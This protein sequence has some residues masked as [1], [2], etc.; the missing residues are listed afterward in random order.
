MYG[1]SDRQS[2]GFPCDEI[3]SPDR[4]SHG[5]QADSAVF[6]FCDDECCT[7]R[8]TTQRHHCRGARHTH[9]RNASI[10]R[11]FDP[12]IAD[13][14]PHACLTG[15]SRDRQEELT[16]WGLLVLRTAERRASATNR[17][18]VDAFTLQDVSLESRRSQWNGLFRGSDG[19]ASC[20]AAATRTPEHIF[21][22][23]VPIARAINR[24]GRSHGFAATTID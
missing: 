1:I 2:G 5:M 18:A 24:G 17:R 16:T 14:F 11:Y 7:R 6:A 23:F 12:F 22:S 13:P 9:E 8:P 20:Q 4:K 3:D 15:S 10:A 21:G 19:R